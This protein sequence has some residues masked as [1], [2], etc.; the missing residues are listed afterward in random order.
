MED[1]LTYRIA[2]FIPYDRAIYE[3]L[4]ERYHAALWPGMLAIVVAGL[5]ALLA[6]G[7]RWDGRLVAVLL[8]V[9]WGWVAWGF[10]HQRYAT[11]N[12][13]AD[14]IAI[15]FAVEAV[16]LLGWA[17]SAGGLRR[18]PDLSPSGA[19]GLALGA[20]V[21]VGLP[22]LVWQAGGG[23]ATLSFAGVGPDATAIAT[24]AVLLATSGRFR[25]L[26]APVPLAWCLAGWAQSQVLGL[27]G[28]WVF[29]ATLAVAAF[30]LLGDAVV[31]RRGAR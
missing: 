7:R 23:W 30:A 5:L 16:L 15:G 31:R 4:F 21:L 13:G 26:L 29:P 27:P 9:G 3:G 18:R 17:V 1:L 20:L 28:A 11:L 24:L 19:V 2:D 14:Q 22:L 25:W 8:A 10:F 12:W 6:L